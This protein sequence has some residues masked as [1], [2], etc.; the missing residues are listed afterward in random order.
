LDGV[1]AGG[2]SAIVVSISTPPSSPSAERDGYAASDPLAAVVTDVVGVVGVG[3]NG[4]NV[5]VKVC[6]M[7]QRLASHS[8]QVARVATVACNVSLPTA[9]SQVFETC[10]SLIP[11]PSSLIPHP[12]SLSLYTPHPHAF[13]TCACPWGMAMGHGHCDV[14]RHGC[15][16][17]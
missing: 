7:H 10:A 12:V 15:S 11:H 8:P 14:H 9:H 4:T 16:C 13:E 5:S 3:L 2:D 6:S 1:V 17:G